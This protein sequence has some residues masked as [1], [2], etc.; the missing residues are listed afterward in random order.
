[1]SKLLEAVNILL[2]I[3]AAGMV[4]LVVWVLSILWLESLV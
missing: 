1:M 2:A 3:I 4:S